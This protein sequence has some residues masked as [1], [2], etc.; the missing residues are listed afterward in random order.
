[1]K[2]L[3]LVLFSI[4]ASYT[5]NAQY[6]PLSGLGTMT[7]TIYSGTASVVHGWAANSYFS[8][9]DGNGNRVGYLQFKTGVAALV[10]EYG[11]R[12]IA[13]NPGG[14]NVGIGTDNPQDLLDVRGYSVFGS[15]AE[16]V[17]LGSNSLGFNRKVFDGAIYDNSR[18]AYQF[19]HNPNSDPSADNLAI[20]IYHPNG[21]NISP[22]A[23]VVNARAQVGINTLYIPSDFVLA[24]NGN[25]IANSLTIKLS[26]SWPDYVFNPSYKLLSIGEIKTYVDKHHHLPEVPS[27]KEVLE[28]GLNV[29]EM[30]AI[31]LKKI[32]ELTL[33]LIKQEERVDAQDQR[34]SKQAVEIEK[35]KNR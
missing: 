26:S 33:L 10:S 31:L 35:L 15:L 12:F 9:A 19:Q 27:E 3:I 23:L 11:S 34:I 22:K 25:M 30:N 6:L 16:K 20:Q 28:K 4:C 13:L 5:S 18:F 17:S 21:I 24:V 32:E 2:K 1:M 8:G 29:G 7:G 14:G